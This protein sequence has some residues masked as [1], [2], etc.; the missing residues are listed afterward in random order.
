MAQSNHTVEELSAQLSVT[1]GELEEARRKCNLA[2]EE[3]KSIRER[4]QIH[5]G[6]DVERYTSEISGLRQLVGRL[7]KQANEQKKQIMDRDE[8]LKQFRTD[9]AVIAKDQTVAQLREE[10]D[11]LRRDIEE[12]DIK[13][14]SL[15]SDRDSVDE[16]SLMGL[17]SV[18]WYVEYSARVW[19]GGCEQGE[20]CDCVCGCENVCA[21]QWE[22]MP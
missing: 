21:L 15:K 7:S 17:W 4:A 16:V 22:Q 18:C 11:R 14:K 12:A 10:N 5:F 1:N 19:R 3:V 8:E 6:T 13:L 9:P 2:E 20:D